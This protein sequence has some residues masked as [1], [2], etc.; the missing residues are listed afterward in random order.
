MNGS[1]A[2][3]AD[4][5]IIAYCHPKRRFVSPRQSGDLLCHF[6]N[7]SATG[8]AHALKEAEGGLV[9]AVEVYDAKRNLALCK[10]FPCEWA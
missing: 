2:N 1:M 5:F 4:L 8:K 7:S 3:M 6:L 10:R 9:R